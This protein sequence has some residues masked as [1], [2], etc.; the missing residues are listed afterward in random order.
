MTDDALKRLKTL[1]DQRNQIRPENGPEWIRQVSR[2]LYELAPAQAREFGKVTPILV[3]GLSDRGVMPYWEKALS[4]ISEGIAV[5]E[6]QRSEGT[7]RDTVVPPVSG[8]MGIF[9]SW[10][11]SASRALAHILYD[12]LPAVLPF[13]DPWMSSEDIPKGSRWDAE[14]DERLQNASYCIVCLTPGIARE[15]WVNYEAGA[16]GKFVEQSRVSP[17]LL[18]V[19]QDELAKLSLSRFQCTAFTKDEILKLLE[20]INTAA[21]TPMPA[22]KLSEALESSWTDI[23]DRVD[24]IN[25]DNIQPSEAKMRE[26]IEDDR[27]AV[28]EVEERILISVSRMSKRIEDIATQIGENHIRTEYFL[29]RLVGAGYLLKFVSI[30]GDPTTYQ[31]SSLGRSYLV[32]NAL[33]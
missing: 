26:Q 5:A 8:S 11:G 25:L 13:V 21:G 33:V 31:I 22:N 10:S 14:L 3:A 27:A 19:T 16:I 28:N 20:S 18:G 32:E 2:R 7:K 30:I 15:P 6:R 23:V 29:D 12:W 24:Q 17:L 9:L 4:I 1:Y